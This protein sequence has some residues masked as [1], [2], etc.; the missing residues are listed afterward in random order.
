MPS[1]RPRGLAALIV[2]ASLAVSG[3]LATAGEASDLLFRGDQI[4][5]VS[6]GTT[7]HYDHQRLG[8]GGEA[9]HAIPEGEIHLSIGENETGVREALV[10]L[11]EG[12]QRRQLDP[13][14]GSAGNPVLLVF[15]ES[16]LRSMARISGGSPY[17][18]R[19]RLKEAL[20]SAELAAQIETELAGDQVIAKEIRVRPFEDDRNRDKLGALADVELTFLVSNSIPGAFLMMSAAT[21]AN[22]AGQ[23]AFLETVT[24][25]NVEESN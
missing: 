18:I 11:M 8:V 6:N 21:P 12:E 20:F 9:L 15:L 1:L 10:T 3:N 13:F 25:E 5:D 14:P 7:L 19:N 23:V 2:T 24:L 4:A 17:Y 22:D 16:S